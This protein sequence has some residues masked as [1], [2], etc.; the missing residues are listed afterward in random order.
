LLE[1]RLRITIL[2]LK[3]KRLLDSLFNSIFYLVKIVPCT[4]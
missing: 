1:G 3:V 2:D 4:S